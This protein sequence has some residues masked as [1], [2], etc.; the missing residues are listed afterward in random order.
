MRFCVLLATERIGGTNEELNERRHILSISRSAN[1]FICRLPMT[2]AVK[3]TVVSPSSF[4]LAVRAR[5]VTTAH[6]RQK[7]LCP[8]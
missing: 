6:L 1:E 4:E 5:H 8:I 3:T 2:E 7:C